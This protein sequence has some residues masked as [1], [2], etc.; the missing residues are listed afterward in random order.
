VPPR[1]SSLRP[2]TE[3]QTPAPENVD[4]LEPL[5]LADKPPQ[6]HSEVLLIIGPG[7]ANFTAPAEDGGPSL[8]AQ[9][10]AAAAKGGLKLRIV[11]DGKTPITRA[12]LEGLKGQIPPFTPAIVWAHGTTSTGENRQHFLQL[13]NGSD[14]LMP[15]TEVLGCLREQDDIS[16]IRTYSC[17]IGDVAKKTAADSKLMANQNNGYLFIGGSQKSMQMEN[18]VD[19]LHSIEYYADCKEKGEMPS[20]IMQHLYQH[21]RSSPQCVKV[22]TPA[23]EADQRGVVGH[24]K[25]LKTFNDPVK[26]QIDG[27]TCKPESVEDEMK[28]SLHAL[29]EKEKPK[30]EPGYFNSALMQRVYRNDFKSVKEIV[31]FGDADINTKTSG[32]TPLY[33]ACCQAVNAKVVVELLKHPL[34][35]VNKTSKGF[36]P[37]Y[38]ACQNDKPTVVEALLKHPGIDLNLPAPNDGASILAMAHRKGFW[39]IKQAL[40]DR[41]VAMPPSITEHDSLF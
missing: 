21:I 12:A 29:N 28:A 20:D 18:S 23:K 10:E 6:I 5:A 15:T 4:A 38:V 16:V 35:E 2:R 17:C 41:G 13:G 1:S 9:Y 19:I 7:H 31:E 33:A 26:E 37:L 30:L 25:G 34:I 36:S 22:V 40:I 8:K 32:F 11:G 3:G 14:S 27:L 24:I 39:Q